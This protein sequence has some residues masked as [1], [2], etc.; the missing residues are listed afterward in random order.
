[1]P[2][3]YFSRGHCYRLSVEEVV[4]DQDTPGRLSFPS[5]LQTIMAGRFLSAL[6]S[7]Q[8]VCPGLAESGLL[9]PTTP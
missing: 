8:L 3:M 2:F 9:T 6:V 5:V 7:Q 4:F 1:M